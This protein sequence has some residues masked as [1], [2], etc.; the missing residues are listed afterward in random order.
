MIPPR[1]RSGAASTTR[2]HLTMKTLY[3]KAIEARELPAAWQQEGQYSPDDRVTVWVEPQDPEL[4]GAASLRE[5][6]DIVGRRARERGL[7][8]KRLRD[9]LNER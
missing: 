4:A 8:K 1:E 5:L 6:M 7:T 3:K 9:I 2:Y